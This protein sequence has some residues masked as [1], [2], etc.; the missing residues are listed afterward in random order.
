MVRRAFR[1]A[2]SDEEVE[3][4]YA[5]AWLGTLRTLE[6]RHESMEDEE[7]RRYLLTAVANHAS[8]ELRRRRRKPIAPLDAVGEVSDGMP[9]PDERASGSEESLVTRDLL[10]TMPARRRAVMLFRYGWGLSPEQVQGLVKGLSPRAYRREIS[11]GVEELTEKMRLLRSGQWCEDREPV[12]RAYAAGIASSEER[13]QARRHLAHCRPCAS[14]VGGLTRALHD[15][16]S[17]AAATTVAG[18]HHGAL[19]DRLADAFWRVRDGAAGLLGRTAPETAEAAVNPGALGLRGAGAGGA[20]VVAKLAGLGSGA[21]VAAICALGGVAASACVA[22]GVAPLPDGDAAGGRPPASPPAAAQTTA[23][24]PGISD[25]PIS[26][27]PQ[28]PTAGESGEDGTGED[29]TA[30][31]PAAA[32]EPVAPPAEQQFGVSAPATPSGGSGGGAATE[33]KASAAASEFGP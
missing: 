14:Y 8:K 6:R 29:A 12:L 18:S 4:I 27:Q 1:G 7:V 16:G 31:E 30:S 24:T 33:S 13:R 21:K 23:P 20:G 15:L 9:A 26:V 22:A 28:E 2:F 3:D 32:P 17:L 10:A 11:R 19:G 5:N 25:V